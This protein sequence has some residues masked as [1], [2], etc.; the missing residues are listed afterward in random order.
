MLANRLSEN[1]EVSVLLLE[2][3]DGDDARYI[4]E[5]PY[6]ASELRATDL[7]WAYSTVPQQNACLS[8]INQVAI[9]IV[10][11]NLI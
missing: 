3:G 2:A 11:T 5:I 4:V 7:D 1:A 9:I 8:C 10:T 6:A